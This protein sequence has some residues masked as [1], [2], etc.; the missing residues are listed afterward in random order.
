ML[1]CFFPNVGGSL[2]HDLFIFF[3]LLLLFSLWDDEEIVIKM[4]DEEGEE[5]DMDWC[6]WD[7]PLIL[8]FGGYHC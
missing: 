2:S 8:V 1:Y 5:Q 7:P 4:H 3:L 6:W